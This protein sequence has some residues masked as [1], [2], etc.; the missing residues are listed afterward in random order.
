MAPSCCNG[1]GGGLL[2]GGA[3]SINILSNPCSGKTYCCPSTTSAGGLVTLLSG[4][5]CQL[6][7]L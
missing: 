7:D 5:F 4:G 2:L 6:L 3:C 1:G